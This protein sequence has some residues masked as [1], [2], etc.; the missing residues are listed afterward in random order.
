MAL[1]IKEDQLIIQEYET[2]FHNNL[3]PNMKL[4]SLPKMRKLCL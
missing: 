1:Y 4:N 3:N 2:P